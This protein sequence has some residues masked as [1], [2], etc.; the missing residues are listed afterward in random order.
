M[1]KLDLETATVTLQAELDHSADL[2]KQ[3]KNAYNERIEMAKKC[4]EK[5]DEV[6]KGYKNRFL[7]QS[8]GFLNEKRNSRG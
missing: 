4:L 2:E 8:S 6:K 5:D 3:L 1:S 7:K